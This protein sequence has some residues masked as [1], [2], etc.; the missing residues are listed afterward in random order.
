M[1]LR[2]EETQAIRQVLFKADPQGR[3]FLF[4]SRVSDEKKGGDI[5]VFFESSKKLDLKTK[6]SLEYQLATLC[7]TKVDLLVKNPGQA[8][9]AIFGIAR[10]GVSL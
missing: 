4:G 7:E 5:D 9:T 1:R 3:I 6:L 10:E 8:E 2:P